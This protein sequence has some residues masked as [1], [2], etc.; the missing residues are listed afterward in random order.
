MQPEVQRV[1]WGHGHARRK[2]TGLFVASLPVRP[3][4]KAITL[5]A[6]LHEA[7]WS[8]AGFPLQSLARLRIR[9]AAFKKFIMIFYHKKRPI[10]YMLGL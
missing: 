8:K 1:S 6:R 5:R 7:V 10:I 4:T 9:Q 3:R 2:A